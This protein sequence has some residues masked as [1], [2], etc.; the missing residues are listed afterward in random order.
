[1]NN[2]SYSTK[3]HRKAGKTKRK[4]KGLEVTSIRTNARGEVILS[5]AAGSHT[6]GW[7]KRAIADKKWIKRKGEYVQKQDSRNS[8]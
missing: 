6:F 7:L 2:Y 8:V 5:L 4:N 1:M 3:G